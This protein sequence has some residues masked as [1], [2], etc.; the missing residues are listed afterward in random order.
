MS[1]IS[2]DLTGVTSAFFSFALALFFALAMVISIAARYRS[3]DGPRWTPRVRSS[4]AFAL[5]SVAW[6]PVPPSRATLT[7]MDDHA[8]FWLAPLPISW[9][10]LNLWLARRLPPA[11][12]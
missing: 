2:I 4:L 10:L 5:L 6:V 11:R 7:W 12:D 8:P 9:L 1:D 3:G